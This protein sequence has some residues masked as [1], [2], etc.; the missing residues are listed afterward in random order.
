MVVTSRQFDAES[1]LRFAKKVSFPA[2]LAIPLLGGVV[3]VTWS[4]AETAQALVEPAGAEPAETE[5]VNGQA[6]TNESAPDLARQDP[7][8]APEAAEKIED[9]ALPLET[10]ATDAPGAA[11]D[12]D[13]LVAD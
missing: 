11:G 3:A 10:S 2:I 1:L 7:A 13:D 12:D 4:T 8:P 6:A 9:P 5:R